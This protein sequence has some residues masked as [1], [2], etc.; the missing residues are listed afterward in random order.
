MVIEIWKPIINY[1]NLYEISNC[2]R[3]KRL[4]GHRCIKGRIL[5]Q[6]KCKNGYLRVTLCKR[7]VCKR[8]LVHRLVLETFIGSCPEGME[9]CHNDGNRGNNFTENLRWDTHKNNGQDALNHGSYSNRKGIRGSNVRLK[10]NDIIKIKELHR[11]GVTSKEIGKIFGISVGHVNNI[12]IGRCW[13][14]IK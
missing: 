7:G 4:I 13:T 5:K 14:H 2:G 1:E 3:I 8:Y 6:E 12:I 10:D 11:R 9:G